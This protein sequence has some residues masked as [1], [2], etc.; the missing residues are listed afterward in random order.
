MSD[1]AVDAVPAPPG[2]VTGGAVAR[3]RRR[4]RGSKSAG[5]RITLD[6]MTGRDKLTMGLM[7]GIPT[8]LCLALIWLPTVA[9]IGLSF[10]NWRGITGLTWNNVDRPAELRHAVHEVPVLLAGTLPQRS[11]GC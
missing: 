9:S 1:P 5:D 8:F 7:V 4:G 10:T 6:R 3:P 11:C 2:P